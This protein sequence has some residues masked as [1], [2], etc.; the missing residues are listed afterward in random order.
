MKLLR[1]YQNQT[2]LPSR[3]TVAPSLTHVQLFAASGTAA[4]QAPLFST[5]SW[6]LL[7]F[8]SAE[9]VML[10]NHLILCRRPLLFPPSIF[11]SFR[12][13]SS[14]SVLCIRWPN[15]W[16]FSFNNSPFNE[17]SGLISFRMDCLQSKG[18]SRVFI[19]GDVCKSKVWVSYIPKN[20]SPSPPTHW[21]YLRM[22]IFWKT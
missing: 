14:E 3:V 10:S 22:K 17:R 21:S 1:Y 16:S 8:M 6:S 18:L 12:V 19:N 7:R 20:P 2:Q 9:S 5:V 13:F 11:P 15:Y 4:C